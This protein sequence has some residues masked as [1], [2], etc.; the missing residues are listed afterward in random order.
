MKSKQTPYPTPEQVVDLSDFDL[1]TDMTEEIEKTLAECGQPT[2]SAV[3][4]PPKNP[5]E[6]KKGWF[7]SV[8]GR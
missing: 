8:L 1:P 5:P 7:R 2:S 3:E 4:P 6:N